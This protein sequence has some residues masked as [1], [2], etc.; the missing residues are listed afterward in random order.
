VVDL[1]R[2]SLCAG[3]TLKKEVGGRGGVGGKMGRAKCTGGGSNRTILFTSLN[4][5]KNQK[6]LA[7]TIEA[8]ET[9]GGVG[10]GGGGSALCSRKSQ[11]RGIPPPTSS[12]I[13]REETLFIESFRISPAGR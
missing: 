2:N 12:V 1:R 5:E 7:A 10:G 8:R 9:G 13:I 6:G 3:P 4:S 11:P